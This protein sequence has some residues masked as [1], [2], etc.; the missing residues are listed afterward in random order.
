MI[1]NRYTYAKLKILRSLFSKRKQRPFHIKVF[2]T[3]LEKNKYDNFISKLPRTR[4]DYAKK[5]KEASENTYDIL[6]P[7]VNSVSLRNNERPI[8]LTYYLE[9]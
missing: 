9:D 2:M 8:T 5:N 6:E 3:K 4:K 1:E 7:M